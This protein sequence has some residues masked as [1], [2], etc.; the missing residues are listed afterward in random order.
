MNHILYEYND[1]KGIVLD[2]ASN[3]QKL[4]LMGK[5]TF[6]VKHNF[7]DLHNFF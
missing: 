4:Y 5:I 3:N 1:I 2:D 6:Y 7:Y